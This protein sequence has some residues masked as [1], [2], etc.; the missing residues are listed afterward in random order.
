MHGQAQASRMLMRLMQQSQEE[1]LIWLNSHTGCTL[2]ANKP[3][4]WLATSASGHWSAQLHHVSHMLC[5]LMLSRDQAGQG[6]HIYG[7]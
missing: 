7:V 3:G 6:L 2:H 1:M 4:M 5:C